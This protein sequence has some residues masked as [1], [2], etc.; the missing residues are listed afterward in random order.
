[1][2]VLTNRLKKIAAAV[3]SMAMVVTAM[4][5]TVFAAG[6]HNDDSGHVY[7]EP[8]IE[9]I[10][11]I[12]EE[13]G[14]QI[15]LTW[16]WSHL[17]N[18]GSGETYAFENANMMIMFDDCQ[19][20]KDGHPEN[21]YRVQSNC[22]NDNVVVASSA[23]P[24]YLIKEIYIEK[25]NKKVFYQEFPDEKSIPSGNGDYICNIKRELFTSDAKLFIRTKKVTNDK[26]SFK[27]IHPE[28]NRLT[29]IKVSRGWNI[30]TVDGKNYARFDE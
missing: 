25:N 1:M 5:M 23:T 7:Y 30:E 20:V 4:P 26:V 2:S 19:K 29:E 22:F 11:Q 16:D 18:G 3:L 15:P 9:G 21:Y 27:V 24:R 28:A 12:V 10:Y 8:E 13:D 17:C 14:T 6:P